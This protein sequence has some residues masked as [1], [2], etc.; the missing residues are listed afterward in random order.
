MPSPALARLR[1]RI[2]ALEG[3]G[4]DGHGP[5]MPLGLPGFEGIGT[6]ALHEI[7][8]AAL[9]CDH[10]GAALGFSAALLGGLVRLMGKPALWLAEGG[11]PHAPA[12]AGFGLGPERLVVGIAGQPKANLWALEEAAR[13]PAL[14]AVLGEVRGM[15]FTAARRLHLAARGSGV[16][17]L[18]LNRAAAAIAPAQTRWRVNGLA[19]ADDR[20][21]LGLLRCRGRSPDERGVVGEWEVEWDGTARRLGLVASTGHRP[22]VPDAARVA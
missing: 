3:V 15:D 11:L 4:G 10:D 14:A 18:L 20:W 6:G 12:L 1:R 5:V 21:R 22:A 8:P 2:A 16:T 17:V 7:S 13:S 19:G 9:A